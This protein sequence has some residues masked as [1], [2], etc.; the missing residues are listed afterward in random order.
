[1]AVDGRDRGPP[2]IPH[3]ILI[4]KNLRDGLDHVDRTGYTPADGPRRADG[5]YRSGKID[6][7]R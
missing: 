3:F 5:I 4:E 1:M 2:V 7:V 6:V